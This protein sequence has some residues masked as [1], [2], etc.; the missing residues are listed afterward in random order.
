M[1]QNS[2]SKFCKEPPVTSGEVTLLKQLL[3]DLLCVFTLRWLLESLWSNDTLETLELESVSGWHEVVVVDG[4]EGAG[5]RQG[6]VRAFAIM[7]L[8]P[9][10]VRYLHSP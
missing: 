5:G 7:I 6:D 1:A 4:L 9:A 10:Y 3:D 8:V 2:K